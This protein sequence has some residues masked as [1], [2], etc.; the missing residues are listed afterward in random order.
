MNQQQHQ[1]S[2]TFSKQR[3]QWFALI[4]TLLFFILVLIQFV[5]CRDIG[6]EGK[7]VEKTL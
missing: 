1:S 6:D 5:Y 3:K 4:A 7:Q 2:L